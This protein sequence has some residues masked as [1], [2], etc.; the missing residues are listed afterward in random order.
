ML[1]FR[2]VG[3]R[4]L[5]LVVL[6]TSGCGTVGLDRYGFW[7]CVC[8]TRIYGMDWYG[9]LG[10]HRAMIHNEHGLGNGQLLDF[11]GESE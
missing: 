9:I 3:Q 8:A 10:V 7:V 5:L 11:K 1:R 2:L 4:S 6:A